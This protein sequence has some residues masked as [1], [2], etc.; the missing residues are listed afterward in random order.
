[1]QPMVNIA[2]RAARKAGDIIT[3]VFDRSDSLQIELKGENDFV[4]QIDRAA[5]Q[6]II[7]MIKQSYPHHDILGE[8]SGLIQAASTPSLYKWIID[9]LDGTTNFIRNIS[10]FAVSIA[11]EYKGR[12]EHA[13]VYDPM[14]KE[15]FYASR[16][17]G[18][19]LNNRRMRVTDQSNAHGMLFHVSMA[20]LDAK[21]T[22]NSDEYFRILRM[23][24]PT[25]SGIRRFGSAALDLAY[26][27]AGRCDV[28]LGVSLKPWDIAAGV[29]LVTEAGGLVSDLK[30]GKDYLEGNV[31]AASP[32]IF[33][34]TLLKIT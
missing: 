33:K 25:G 4:T 8:E 17:Y 27:A 3:Q 11:C 26:L 29:L 16:G 28:A 2:L 5:E 31:L 10:H 6:S 15:E 7:R 34:D 18:A 22:Q 21:K 20:I 13:V 32:R 19:M 14:K 12:L 23:I 9:P 30:G 24:S 1:M